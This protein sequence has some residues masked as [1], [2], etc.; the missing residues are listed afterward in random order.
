MLLLL[1]VL[2][3]LGCP[4][5]AVYSYQKYRA[6]IGKPFGT[7][8]LVSYTIVLAFFTLIAVWL[9]M[10]TNINFVAFI[11]LSFVGILVPYYQPL[12]H[13]VMLEAVPFIFSWILYLIKRIQAGKLNLD[14]IT[15]L[16]TLLLLAGTL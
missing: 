1:K 15:P 14:H 12:F 6:R 7:D 13:A 16:F 4:F 2:I 3:N 11:I 8:Y 10:K 5:L 9:P